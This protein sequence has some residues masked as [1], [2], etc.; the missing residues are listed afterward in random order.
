MA[1]IERNHLGPALTHNP[2]SPP[3]V[4]DVGLW[5]VAE[6]WWD[7]GGVRAGRGSDVWGG[8]CCGG[9]IL[10][11]G[12]VYVVKGRCVNSLRVIILIIQSV[13]V[14]LSR[15]PNSTLTPTP[16]SFCLSA[17]R[18]LAVLIMWDRR[19][20]STASRVC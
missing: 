7:G 10:M 1:T 4:M 8:V 14:N 6:R 3:R 11:L 17:V 20:T 12:E 18:R 9:R 13:S 19:A 16:L 15:H 2:T 5:V